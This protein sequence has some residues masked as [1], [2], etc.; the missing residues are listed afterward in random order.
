MMVNYLYYGDTSLTDYLNKVG[1][2]GLGLVLVLVGFGLIIAAVRD[3]YAGL[4]PANKDMKKAGIGL[5]VGILGALILY[6]G[7]KTITGFFHNLSNE[8]PH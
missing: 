7:S 8:V 3:L 2:W 1:D 6:W 5:A 4:A